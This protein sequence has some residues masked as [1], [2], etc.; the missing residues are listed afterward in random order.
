MGIS[1][2]VIAEKTLEIL[3]S[4]NATLIQLDVT[5]IT[6]EP[7]ILPYYRAIRLS[8]ANIFELS[9]DNIGV[10]AKSQEGMG[11]IGKGNAAACQALAM[12]RYK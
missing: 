9:A 7:K 6:E 1:S 11:A 2:T 5:I 3:K 10:K 4:K 12:V 8:L